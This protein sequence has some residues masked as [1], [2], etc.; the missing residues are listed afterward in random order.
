MCTS[1]KYPYPPS[2]SATKIPKEGWVKKEAI[3]EGA[4]VAYRGFFFPGG[5]LPVFKTSI[6]A[7]LIIF[8][9]RSA[10]SFFFSRLM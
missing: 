9:L 1:I 5:L 2:L 4:R 6:A 8:Y 10:K 3:S 7:A